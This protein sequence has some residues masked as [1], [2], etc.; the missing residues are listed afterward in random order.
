MSDG[1]KSEVA[2]ATIS[3]PRLPSDFSLLSSTFWFLLQTVLAAQRTPRAAP[4]TLHA[5]PSIASPRADASRCG[6]GLRGEQSLDREVALARV[7]AE[8]QDATSLSE[9]RPLLRDR[10]ERGAR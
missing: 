6:S 10:G 5:P 1:Q 7:I 9:L 2:Q 4:H 3:A 8:C